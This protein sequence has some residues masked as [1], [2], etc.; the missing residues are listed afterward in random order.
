MN[1]EPEVE[2]PSNFF[3][4]NM[5]TMVDLETTSS[6]PLDACIT[7][8]GF[9][10]FSIR[11]N[12]E[13]VEIDKAYGVVEK[14]SSMHKERVRGVYNAKTARWRDEN[15]V[16][17][18]ERE[19]LLLATTDRLYT[20]VDIVMYIEDYF[21]ANPETIPVANHP[22]F[23]MSI[24]AR[25]LYADIGF[26]TRKPF[27]LPWKYFAVENMGSL[28]RGLGYDK[29]AIRKELNITTSHSAIDDCCTQ[30][31]ILAEAVKKRYC[32]GAGEE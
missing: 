32:S 18:A 22:E 6:N 3:F 11:R 30:A 7:S 10:T 21:N 9:L 29:S 25:Y 8:I 17:C 14:M 15:G 5:F 24:M 12:G 4:D 16:T 1:D 31:A 28:I 20:A 13:V 27:K 23:D 19:A 2:T 26:N